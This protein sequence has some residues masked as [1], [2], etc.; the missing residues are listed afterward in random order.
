M[1]SGL[2]YAALWNLTHQLKI[3]LM[4]QEQ[5]GVSNLLFMTFSYPCGNG[6]FCWNK[7]WWYLHMNLGFNIQTY[8]RFIKNNER[9]SVYVLFSLPS[10]ESEEGA[11]ILAELI[12]TLCVIQRDSAFL[13]SRWGATGRLWTQVHPVEIFNYRKTVFCTSHTSSLLLKWLH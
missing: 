11:T 1:A 4:N 5:G 12:C 13:P 8:Q 10:A 9:F 7:Y 2:H 3:R 6:C